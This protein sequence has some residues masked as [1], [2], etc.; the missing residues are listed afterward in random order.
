MSQSSRL[1]ACRLRW[2]SDKTSPPPVAPGPS[3]HL[4]R[5]LRLRSHS[6]SPRSTPIHPN[7]K[8]I[9]IHPV[10]PRRLPTSH[11]TPSLYPCHRPLLGHHRRGALHLDLFTTSDILSRPHPALSLDQ[12]LAIKAWQAEISNFA[13]TILW[14]LSLQRIPLPYIR[15][16]VFFQL[17]WATRIKGQAD[18]GPAE[19][20]RVHRISTVSLAVGPCLCPGRQLLAISSKSTGLDPVDL[21]VVR[22]SMQKTSSWF[23]LI[24]PRF[25]WCPHPCPPS[26]HP[27]L[28]LS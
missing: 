23:P 17:G 2:N 15:D 16:F 25:R 28:T 3:L 11:R 14:H 7:A 10:H 22:V 27:S 4:R 18:N 1:S 9:Q 12:N 24:L 21:R 6:L 20:I 13:G 8:T 26:S 5:P 19:T